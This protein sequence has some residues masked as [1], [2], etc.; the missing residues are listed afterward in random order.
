MEC[1]GLANVV[2]F[3]ELPYSELDL[4]RPTARNVYR[5][6]PRCLPLGRIALLRCPVLARPLEFLS[7][8]PGYKTGLLAP[9]GVWVCFATVLNYEIWRLN[10]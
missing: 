8:I 2:R 9:Y 7:S 6:K 4:V 10:R 5:I 1:A 3:F